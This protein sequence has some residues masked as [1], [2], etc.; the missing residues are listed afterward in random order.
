MPP[1]LFWK[2]EHSWD[3]M[4]NQNSVEW[5]IKGKFSMPKRDLHQINMLFDEMLFFFHAGVFLSRHLVP[6]IQI[7]AL[8][9]EQDWQYTL[10]CTL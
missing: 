9:P 6:V 10:I 1:L 7:N 4:S 2:A 8:H 5:T 3:Q